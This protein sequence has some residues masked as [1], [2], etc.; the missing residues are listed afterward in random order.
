MGGC[1]YWFP[2]TRW[3]KTTEI[4][5]HSSG[6]LKFKIKVPERPCSLT[7]EFKDEN[8]RN[9]KFM[10]LKILEDLQEKGLLTKKLEWTNKHKFTS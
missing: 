4:Y 8:F 7:E 9:S 3:L 10:R 6:G 1:I 2:Q 5:S